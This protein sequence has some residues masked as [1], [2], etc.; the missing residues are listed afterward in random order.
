MKYQRID[1][2]FKRKAVD[3]QREEVIIS[4]SEPEQVHENPIIEENESRPLKVNM[5]Y[6]F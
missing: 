1:T 3:I 5:I 6:I 2:I 4:S